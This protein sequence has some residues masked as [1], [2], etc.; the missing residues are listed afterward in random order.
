MYPINFLGQTQGDGKCGTLTKTQTFTYSYI[1]RNNTRT[2]KA[3]A[4]NELE[5]AGTLFTVKL[6]LHHH[7][8]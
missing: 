2:M 7:G 6:A 5:G 8:V 4:C 1:V 3:Q